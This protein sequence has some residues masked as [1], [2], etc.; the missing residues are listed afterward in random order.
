MDI[1]ANTLQTINA[2][3]DGVSVCILVAFGLYFL[4]GK[5]KRPLFHYVYGVAMLMI[6]T[7]ILLD[8]VLMAMGLYDSQY[9]ANI[10]SLY[11][12]TV[13]PT[14]MLI[15]VCVLKQTESVL[16]LI[17]RTFVMGLPF[18]VFIVGYAVIPDDVWIFSALTYTALFELFGIIYVSL[19]IRNYHRKLLN[20]YSDIEGRKL[21]WLYKVLIIVVAT[22]IDC[23]LVLQ[24]LGEDYIFIHI[25]ACTAAWAYVG[26]N[27]SKQR[28]VDSLMMDFIDEKAP[29]NEK[30]AERNRLIAARLQER[31]VENRLY[32]NPDLTIREVAL[33]LGTNGSYISAYLNG[34]LGKSFTTYI[35]EMRLIDVERL[36]DKEKEMPLEKIAKQTGFNS[37]ATMNRVFAA[38]NGCSPTAYRQKLKEERESEEHSTANRLQRMAQESPELNPSNLEASTEEQKFRI[39]IEHAMPGIK[40]LLSANIAGITKREELIVMLILLGKDNDEICGLLGIGKSSLSVFRSRIRAKVGLKRNQSLEDWLLELLE[41]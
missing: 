8:V 3:V 36:L 25:I 2:F 38:K 17:I 29:V 39:A 10:S 16:S 20:S 19:G 35:N 4:F 33:E 40:S 1:L 28:I 37:A 11:S 6:S 12:V 41:K 31:I 32:T 24:F 9:H 5:S 22:T 26:M 21:D 13:I 34:V 30:T 27:I 23:Y 15:F 18:V 7:Q 14:M